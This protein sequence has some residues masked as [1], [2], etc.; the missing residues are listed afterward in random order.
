MN[1]D[2]DWLMKKIRDGVVGLGGD[3][4][5][6]A[7]TMPKRPGADPQVVLCDDEVYAAE[8]AGLVNLEPDGPVSFTKAGRR[9]LEDEQKRRSAERKA[10]R[11]ALRDDVFIAPDVQV[12]A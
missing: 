12:A 10:A 5:Y 6:Y 8:A 3:W 11:K 1:V 9:L 2:T 4:L 7:T